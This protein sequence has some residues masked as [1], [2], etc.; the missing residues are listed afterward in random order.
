MKK[1]VFSSFV[2]TFMIFIFTLVPV[3]ARSL[4]SGDYYG[5]STRYNGDMYSIDFEAIRDRIS[6]IDFESVIDISSYDGIIDYDY[7]NP[8]LTND[9][10]AFYDDIKTRIS[11]SDVT[12]SVN[13]A[14]D[15]F[16]EFFS[17]ENFPSFS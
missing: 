9:F 4:S 15:R 8:E 7:V 3:G 12:D 5:N 11:E 6:E 16:S 10:K 1:I 13:G 2:I 14:L 17:V